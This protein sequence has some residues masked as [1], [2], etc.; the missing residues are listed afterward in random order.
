MNTLLELYGTTYLLWSDVLMVPLALMVIYTWAK[1]VARKNHHNPIY[2][3][4]VPGLMLKMFGGIL[5]C[6]VYIFYYQG[7]DTMGY[8]ADSVCMAKLMLFDFDKFTYIMSV[9]PDLKEMYTIFDFT[10]QYPSTL[11]DPNAFYV[12]KLISVFTFTTLHSYLLTTLIV[13]C[14]TF[15]GVWQFYKVL[16]DYYPAFYKEIG[17]A[18]FFIPSVVFWGSGI[19]KDSITLGALGWYLW[20]FYFGLIK[21]KN[22]IMGMLAIVVSAYI[23]YKIKVYILVAVLPGSMIWLLTSGLK[24]VRS[25]MIRAILMP[26]LAAAG[27]FIGYNMLSSM[28]QYLG[29]YSTEKVF[30]KAAVNQFDL[31]Q[32]HYG[33]NSFDIGGFDPTLEGVTSK[34]HLA[35]SAGLFR[36]FLWEARNPMMLI[37]G[38]ENLLLLFFTIQILFRKKIIGFFTSILQDPMLTFAFIFSIIFAFGVGLS[39]SNFGS[40]V[41]YRIPL[42]PFYVMVLLILFKRKEEV[43][44]SKKVKFVSR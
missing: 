27:L 13:S 43:Q 26:I 2:K 29:E 15:T 11:K 17:Y 39:T 7:G 12:V 25:K 4:Y 33:G 18:V 5:V 21:R 34:A 19:L 20:G 37:S 41:R 3:Y 44:Q 24:N 6:F 35:I 22:P 42:L 36:P 38:I 28:N 40:L 8:F 1:Y 31:K 32:A 23:I 16:C 30:K 9:E 10:T 14:I